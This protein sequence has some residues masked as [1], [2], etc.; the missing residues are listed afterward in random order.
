MYTARRIWGLQQ[1]NTVGSSWRPECG[2]CSE[3][4]QNY[5][6]RL[7]IVSRMLW[8]CH[9]PFS[10]RTSFAQLQGTLA[11]ICS[12]WTIL[13]ELPLA[14]EAASLKSMPHASASSHPVTCHCKGTK[15]GLPCLIQ[16][17]SE[18]PPQVQSPGGIGGG[19]ACCCN[20]I[21]SLLPGA[22]GPSF[23]SDVTSAGIPQ[24]A[25]CLQSSI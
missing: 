21:Q 12:S 2:S 25:F 13:Q 3:K 6:F 5:K 20:P 19:L 15:A 16:D 4:G 1:V 18:G 14:E 17:N 24:E 8:C 7:G 23:L 11:A 10:M 9:I 22:P